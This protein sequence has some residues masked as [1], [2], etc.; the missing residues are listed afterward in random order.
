MDVVFGN[1]YCN[2]ICVSH[3]EPGRCDCRE[4]SYSI[5]MTPT[6]NAPIISMPTD[7]TVKPNETLFMRSGRALMGLVAV[8]TMGLLMP[9]PAHAEF[10]VAVYAGKQLTNDGDL[11]LKQ[12][13]TDLTFNDV[14]WEDHSFESPIFYGGRISYWFDEMPGWGLAVDFTHAKTIL[15]ASD[16]VAVKGSRN[17]T[18]VDG[19]EPIS[20]SI[21]HFELSH[22]LNMITF[23][24][25]HRWFPAGKRD[26][27]PMGRMQLYTGLGAGFSIPHVEADIKGER[28]ER[29]QMA[30]GPVINGMLGVN[31]DLFR[32]L[33]GVLEY[34][35]SYADVRADLNGG[36]SIDAATVNHQ[37]IFG[38]AANFRL[39]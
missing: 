21:E 29:Y 15:V 7:T 14:R 37:F 22:G 26:R 13:N 1:S 23:N 9:V 3:N 19:P 33:S 5:C 16:T 27:S 12:G 2:S 38:L 17:G 30:A 24:G 4:M 28:T 11:R 32:F 36:G 35:L 8:L 10:S 18:P 20:G 6:V 34:K 31:Y 25:L 39:W